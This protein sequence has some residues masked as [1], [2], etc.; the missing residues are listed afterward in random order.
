MIHWISQ[1]FSTYVLHPLRNN[2]YQWWSG[3][4]SDLSEV[5]LIAVLLGAAKHRNCHHRG[6]W[7]LGHNHPEHGWPS[8]KRHWNEVPAHVAR[9]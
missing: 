7:R 9:G 8:C 5:T 6:C 1:A 3:A 4:G 2:G